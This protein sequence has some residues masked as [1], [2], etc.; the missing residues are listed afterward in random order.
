[1]VW[2]SSCYRSGANTYTCAIKLVNHLPNHHNPQMQSVSQPCRRAV[3]RLGQ[4]RE[5]LAATFNSLGLPGLASTASDRHISAKCCMWQD[6]WTGCTQRVR[7][8]K[9]YRTQTA[10]P[11]GQTRQTFGCVSLKASKSSPQLSSGA[12]GLRVKRFNG[13]NRAL[14]DRW[15]H[16]G[17]TVPRKGVEEG[18]NY[19]T[20][21][22]PIWMWL[23]GSQRDMGQIDIQSSCCL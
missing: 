21:I 15:H 4:T 13:T 5:Q 16:P 14:G 6:R 17:D 12:G 8:R 23:S 10:A 3:S 1:M 9:R 11:R 20:D 22:T 18:K 19:S 2:V 7:W